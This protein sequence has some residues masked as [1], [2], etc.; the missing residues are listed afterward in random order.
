MMHFTTKAPPINN[1]DSKCNTKKLKSSRTC[2]IGYKI[3]FH[4]NGFYSL[5]RGHTNTHTDFPDKSNFKKPETTR[6]QAYMAMPL[7]EKI[8]KNLIPTF[9]EFQ[10][11]KSKEFAIHFTGFNQ[12]YITN[13]TECFSFIQVAKLIKRPAYS[14]TVRISA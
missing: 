10:L 4:V 9:G 2:L 3:S 12:L 11:A 8:Y 14:V 7:F 5:G 1:I 6:I 13:K